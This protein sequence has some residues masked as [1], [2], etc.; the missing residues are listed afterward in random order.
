MTEFIATC[1]HYD[2]VGYISAGPCLKCVKKIHR[3]TMTGR[4]T[5]L[6]KINQRKEIT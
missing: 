1:G 6:D 2:V 3:E 5:T 4:R